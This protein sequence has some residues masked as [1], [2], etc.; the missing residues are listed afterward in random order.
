MRQ[1]RCKFSYSDGLGYIGSLRPQSILW[2]VGE[3]TR[4]KATLR[5]AIYMH[6]NGR[7]GISLDA[8]IYYE[9]TN[10]KNAIL[11]VDHCEATTAPEVIEDE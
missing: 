3:G 5:P 6:P 1:S 11:L 7:R 9:P 8:R 4:I 10:S 2:R